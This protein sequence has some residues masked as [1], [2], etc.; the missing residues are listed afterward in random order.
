[1]ATKVTFAKGF[2]MD[3]GM[4]VDTYVLCKRAAWED[5]LRVDEM[6]PT[7]YAEFCRIFGMAHYYINEENDGTKLYDHLKDHRWRDNYPIKEWLAKWHATA[8]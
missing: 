4:C 3:R 5:E 2:C 7:D 1:M 8:G 6:N